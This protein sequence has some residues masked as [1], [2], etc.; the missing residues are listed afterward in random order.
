MRTFRIQFHKV[1]NMIAD[2]I[3][4]GIITGKFCTEIVS[5]NAVGLTDGFEHIIRQIPAVIVDRS[6]VGMCCNNRRIG[7]LHDIPE[8]LVADMAHINQHTQAL[9]F[10]NIFL[11]PVRQTAS[12]NMRAGQ[13]VFLI[14]AKTGNSEAD[15]GK[16]FQQFRIIAKTRSTFQRQDCR[17]FSILTVLYNLTGCICNGNN[18]LIRVNF[19]L[20]RSKFPFKNHDGRNT[21]PLF[22]KRGSIT[23]KALSVTAQSGCPLQ[24]DMQCIFTQLTCLI[25]ILSK[26]LQRSVTVKIKYRKIH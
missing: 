10:P 21:K 14:P 25:Y 1:E 22:H 7:N 23:G 13:R 2:R 18:I 3:D 9:C 24:V 19:P 16:T 26:K 5:G 4:S 17:H 6:A 15:Q 12:C 11:T 8:A 20:D